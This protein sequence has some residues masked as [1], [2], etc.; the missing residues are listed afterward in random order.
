MI[1]LRGL[2]V[3]LYAV[4]LLMRD[5]ELWNGTKARIKYGSKMVGHHFRM[6]KNA[7]KKQIDAR[8]NKDVK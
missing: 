3:A 1:G 5:E 4:S 7:A 8:R 2:S 6:A